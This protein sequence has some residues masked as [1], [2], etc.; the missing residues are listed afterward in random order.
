MCILCEPNIFS[1][2]LAYVQYTAHVT[3][4]Y[5]NIQNVAA[6]ILVYT[7]A[8]VHRWCIFSYCVFFCVFWVLQEANKKIF[9]MYFTMSASNKFLFLFF[10]KKNVDLANGGNCKTNK[11]F[12]KC[13]E[14]WKHFIRVLGIISF[15]F[16]TTVYFTFKHVYMWTH[17]KCIEMGWIFGWWWWWCIINEKK[18]KTHKSK[19]IKISYEM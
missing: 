7:H 5:L 13:T 1:L 17:E 4:W 19:R 6:G 8:L 15:F 10:I 11:I 12:V 3:V 14:S 16:S 9:P 2:C 18:E